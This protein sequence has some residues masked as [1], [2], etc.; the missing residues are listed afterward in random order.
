MYLTLAIIDA[1]ASDGKLNSYVVTP[2]DEGGDV[3]IVQREDIN[4][5]RPHDFFELGSIFLH[6]RD[7]CLIDPSTW[8]LPNRNT[9]NLPFSFDIKWDRIHV[10]SGKWIYNLILEP[11]LRLTELNI[12]DPNHEDKEL[13]H[14]VL[15]DDRYKIQLVEIV[16]KSNE[17]VCSF[18]IH[19][20]FVNVDSLEENNFVK[21]TELKEWTSGELFKTK[22]FG[23]F[24]IEKSMVQK[25][26]DFLKSLEWNL[27]LPPIEISKKPKP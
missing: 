8:Y 3:V 5:G 21:A 13:D 6:D 15:W 2:K 24:E 12:V 20:S 1:L 10:K 11:G 14:T 4:A 23:K 16:L 18:N 25:F 19:G 27:I 17:D 7:N 22:E 9:E 26:I